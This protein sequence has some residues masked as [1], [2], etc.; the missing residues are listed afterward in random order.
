TWF[1]ARRGFA[2]AMVISGGAVAS[3]THP[4][5]T[6]ALVRAIGWRPAC[7]VLGGL[8]LGIGLPVV[9]AL[10]RERGSHRSFFERGE[11]EGT[12]ATDALRSWIFW[13]LL[14]VIGG[15]TIATNAIIVHLPA[16]LID[17]GTSPSR[18][19]MALSI[20]GA[21]SL[22]GRLLTGWLVHRFRGT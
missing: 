20:M 18:A 4:P 1:D 7:L 10:V 16:L 14:L 9:F 22:S 12:S 13:V 3:I 19:A 15:A 21:A 8:I 5:T 2:L 11:R 6:D 17:R